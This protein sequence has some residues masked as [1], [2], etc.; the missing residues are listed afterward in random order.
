MYFLD[1]KKLNWI[2]NI[3]VRLYFVF[4]LIVFLI[5][6]LFRRLVRGSLLIDLV[7]IFV[8]LVFSFLLGYNDM[9]GVEMW[10]F[11]VIRIFCRWGIFSV[12]FFV[13][14][15]VKWKV[16]SVIWVDG[17]FM[18]CLVIILMVLFGLMSDFR[19][20]MVKRSLVFFLFRVCL[21]VICLFLLFFLCMR[22]FLLFLRY[23]VICL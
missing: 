1:G 6:I 20:F 2:L 14:W 9:E 5:L 11:V 10:W 13:E 17:L 4:L 19:Y 21:L 18:D 7:K 22:L 3:L 8:V 16:L 12:I 23:F 15:L